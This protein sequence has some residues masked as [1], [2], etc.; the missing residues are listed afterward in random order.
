MCNA[1]DVKMTFNLKDW[2]LPVSKVVYGANT[3]CAN[4]YFCATK[5]DLLMRSV[6]LLLL[7]VSIFSGIVTA[8]E[9][10]S[11]LL[12]GFSQQELQTMKADNPAELSLMEAFANR[13]FAIMDYPK[14][15]KGALDPSTALTID[16]LE[17]FNPLEFG[18]KP[19]D[20]ARIYYPITGQPD[21]MM[22]ILPR[23]ELSTSTE[24]RK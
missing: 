14:Q 19:H 8:Q 1:K 5:N 23:T 6:C 18:L 16:D 21:K 2:Q 4:C 3:F 15:K 12:A 7:T 9:F 24:Q 20:H 17:T 22:A 11:R 10:D 13:G